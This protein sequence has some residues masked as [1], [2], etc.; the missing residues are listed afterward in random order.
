MTFH[1]HS[2]HWSPVT[3]KNQVFMILMEHN[4][5]EMTVLLSWR[6][7][8]LA[9]IRFFFCS[10]FSPHAGGLVSLVTGAVHSCSER[11]G[12][13]ACGRMHGMKELYPLHSHQRSTPRD[14]S[15]RDPPL[16]HLESFGIHTFQ[17]HHSSLA[18]WDLPISVLP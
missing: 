14:R 9:K 6:R 7:H 15:R 11:E 16:T 3:N 18:I 8:S 13:K 4:L 5:P 10:L 2:V 12:W 1:F 17:F